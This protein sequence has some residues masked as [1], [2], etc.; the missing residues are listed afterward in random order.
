MP[1]INAAS[2]TYVQHHELVIG[3]D[4][5]RGENGEDTILGG[6]AIFAA[7]IVT[8]TQGDFVESV[9]ADGLDSTSL[10]LLV[11]SMNET[12]NEQA[13]DLV[14]RR[15]ARTINMAEQLA[16]RTPINRIA[17]VPSFDRSLDNDIIDSGAGNDLVAGDDSVIVT[18]LVQTAPTT[19]LELDDLDRH[20]ERLVNEIAGNDRAG[21]TF[22]FDNHIAR[23]RLAQSGTDALSPTG[24][25]GQIA[26]QW[27]IEND[28]ID[29][30]DGD[31]TVAGD[32]VAIVSPLMLDD[33]GK[34]VTLRRSTYQIGYL[35]DAMKEFLDSDSL[36]RV[37]VQL[38]EDIINGE[39]GNDE[40]L[41]SV[42]DDEINGGDGDD[43]LRGGN[44]N[45]TLRGGTGDDVER[46]DGGNYPN[47]DLGDELGAFSFFTSPQLT[48]QLLFDAAAGADMP[49]NWISDTTT[50]GNTGGENGDPDTPVP[51]V[52]RI[53]EITA[54]DTAVTGQP[55][56]FSALTTDL[57]AGATDRFLWE[58]KDDTGTLIAVGS[59]SEYGFTATE[60][61]TYTIS[62][63]GT[64]TDNG[65]GV[66]THTLTVFE[67]RLIADTDNP[68][69]FI[70]VLGGTEF[71]DDIRLDDVRNKPNSVEIRVG[72]GR[73]ALRTTYDNISRV[74][75][76]GGEG[77]DHL[78][79]DRRLTIPLR[80]YGGAGNDKLRGGAASD[81]LD[82]GSGDDSIYGHGGDDVLIGGLGMDRL[83]G[84][85]GDDLIIT[86]SLRQTAGVNDAVSLT[87]RWINSS[88]T[89][90]DRMANLLTDL[91][92]T[93]IQDGVE[94]EVD[95]DDGRDWIFA[96]SIDDTRR[97]DSED[98]LTQP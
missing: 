2:A 16:I 93:I 94:D 26:G 21:A 44:E 14:D 96:Q 5:I 35:E 12:A 79:S 78:T 88:D 59:L 4:T 83:H 46:R 65:L 85:D 95:G 50:S 71:D 43:T 31:D 8:G 92:P 20:V 67:T 25:H 97:L 69:Q 48:K 33:T 90:A 64:D 52:T 89:V 91:R 70:L 58:V 54:N 13:S 66:A 22:S 72:Q 39:D 37:D 19:Q 73:T 60:P 63:T 51:P 6:N 3:G 55:V 29:A 17:Y 7:P 42:G 68:G 61:G 9:L 23:Q 82:G 77:N 38:S 15:G 74:D 18:P 49:A 75:I 24:R 10:N 76:H 86:G 80:I 32:H 36:T 27:I 98:V 87:D 62:V 28:E 53:V 41:G 40:L 84:K 56:T 57:P 45:D 34:Q 47:L 1:A 81:F 30:G 11:D